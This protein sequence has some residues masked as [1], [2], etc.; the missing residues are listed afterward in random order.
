[1]FILLAILS[2]VSSISGS[3]RAEKSDIL[4][5]WKKQASN[6]TVNKTGDY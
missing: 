5:Q 2:V 6:K 3:G 4:V 1:M